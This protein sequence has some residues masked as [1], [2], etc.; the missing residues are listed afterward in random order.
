MQIEQAIVEIFLDEGVTT[1]FG[2]PGIQLVRLYDA[3]REAGKITHILFK[4]EQGVG[5]AGLGYS[6]VKNVP[7]V[8]LVMPGPG[9]ANIVS[10]VAEA[11]YQSVP[12]V[13]ITI[14]TPQKNLGLGV[15]H[16]LNSKA[17]FS[18]IVKKVLI[19]EDTRQILEVLRKGFS[20]AKSGRPGP[21]L[22]SLPSNLFGKE[23]RKIPGKF[24]RKNPRIKKEDV[25]R[26]ADLLAS[27]KNPLIWAGEGVIRAGASDLLYQLAEILQAPVMTNLSGRGAFD[28]THPLAMRVPIYDLP[29]HTLEGTDLLLAIGIKLTTWNTTGYSLPVPKNLIQVDSEPEKRCRYKKALEIKACPREFLVELLGELD[30]KI[31]KEKRENVVL[32]N[33]KKSLRGYQDYWKPIASKETPPVTP[34]RFFR[35]LIEYLGGKEFI[36]VTDYTWVLHCYQSPAISD[37]AFHI[38]IGSFGCLGLA[39]PAAIGAALASPEKLIVSISGD[40]SFLFNC[41]ELSTAAHLNLNNLIQVVLVNSGYGSIRNFQKLFC[42]GRTIGVDWRSIDFVKIAE[43]MGVKGFFVREPH[44]IRTALE[45]SQKG[46]ALI[47]VEVENISPM[48]ESVIRDLAK[49]ML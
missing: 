47:A 38:S 39:L 22:I 40:G 29:L 21:V 12:L 3:L 42:G 14:D 41:Q 28:E 19:P 43:G 30:G 34:P 48:S 23:V 16:E 18:S 7:A 45:G 10:A 15:F 2:L 44:E 26:V 46:P 35:E 4:H 9:V 32:E 1:V 27:S 17:L 6:L 33:F 25:V 13:V 8:C 11:F 49:R 5:F 37:K 24:T 36:Y 20:V 31:K